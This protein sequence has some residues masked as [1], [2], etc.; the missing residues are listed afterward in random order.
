MENKY[1][2]Q[3]AIKAK[4]DL[5]RIIMYINNKLKEPEIDKKYLKIITKEIKTLEY[6]PQRFAIVDV[7]S[8]G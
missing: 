4:N 7:N 3:L 6:N 1:K 2:I 5:K 8:I